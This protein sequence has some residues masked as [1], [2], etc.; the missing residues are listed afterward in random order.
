[1]EKTSCIN[2]KIFLETNETFWA[3]K[4]HVLLTRDQYYGIYTFV[5]HTKSREKVLLLNFNP[6]KR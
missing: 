6:E 1:M 3:Q 2:L 4:W 5:F